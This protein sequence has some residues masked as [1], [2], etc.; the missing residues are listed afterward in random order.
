MNKE[1]HKTVRVQATMH[2]ELY[3]NI[4]VPIDLAKEDILQF[5][6]EGNVDGSAMVPVYLNGGW[7]WE[8]PIYNYEFD[9]EAPDVSEEILKQKG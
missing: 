3:S 6:R 1:T 4:N 7:T 2:T 5:I 9:P 8:E